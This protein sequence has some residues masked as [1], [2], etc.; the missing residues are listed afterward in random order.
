[1][2]FFVDEWLCSRSK[3]NYTAFR[4]VF[5]RIINSINK[6]RFIFSFIVAINRVHFQVRECRRYLRA[7]WDLHL[8]PSPHSYLASVRHDP[9]LLGLLPA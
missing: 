3:R 7:G 8:G 4:V 1:M 5:T 9:S 6:L 2:H